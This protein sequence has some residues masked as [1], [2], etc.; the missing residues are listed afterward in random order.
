MKTYTH[1]IWLFGLV[2]FA[3]KTP[4][5]VV[6]NTASQYKIQNGVTD[7][8][9]E[10]EQLLKPYRDNLNKEMKTLIGFAESDF[11]KVRP[12]G[13]LGDLVVDALFEKAMEIDNRTSNAICNFGGIRIPEIP[14][15]DV[16]IGRIFELL[17]FENELVLLSVRGDILKQWI[18]LMD[19]A[20]GWPI[21][22][23][24]QF[25]LDANQGV[26]YGDT[27]AIER[28]NGNMELQIK[29]VYL[30]SDSLYVIATNDYLANGGDQCDFLKSCKRVQT[31]V[32]IRDLM[33]AYVKKHQKLFRIGYYTIHE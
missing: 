24:I 12:S 31:G 4:Y 17:P 13:S 26:F 30:H 2:L 29:K 5:S 20:G 23:P 1:F 9:S 16:T 28:K 21:R 14:K 18:A 10:I 15:G 19:S 11:V 3:C 6:S 33:I 22:K 25:Q 32:L 27:T 8:L 7:T